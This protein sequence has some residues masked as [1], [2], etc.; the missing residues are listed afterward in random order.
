MCLGVLDV[1]VELQWVEVSVDGLPEDADV[2]GCSMR[3]SG[4]AKG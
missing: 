1:L 4:D 3:I 2:G